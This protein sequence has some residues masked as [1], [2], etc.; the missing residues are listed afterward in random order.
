MASVLQAVKQ[1]QL[2][3]LEEHECIAAFEIV[4]KGNVDGEMNAR[5]LKTCLRALGFPA[6][7]SMEANAFIYEFDYKSTRS[8][9]L[10][11]FQRIYLFKVGD[12]PYPAQSWPMLI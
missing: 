2:T 5:Q 12:Q 6:T 8:I 3:E 7:T 1:Q 10:S 4:T 11:D 9:G